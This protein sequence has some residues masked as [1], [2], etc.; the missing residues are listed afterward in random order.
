MS[1]YFG[2]RFDGAEAKTYYALLKRRALLQLKGV[3]EGKDVTAEAD[4]MGDALIALTK[5][6]NLS[7]EIDGDKAYE[8][9]KATA[10]KRGYLTGGDGFT[11]LEFYNALE[12]ME[13]EEKKAKH[14]TNKI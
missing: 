6:L 8:K 12:M 2:Q 1:A 10:R 3:A 5:P 11:V 7:F 4:K 13:Q 14:G 9:A